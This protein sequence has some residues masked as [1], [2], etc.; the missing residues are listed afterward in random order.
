MYGP[1]SE[2]RA[3]ESAS[4]TGKRKGK[5]RDKRPSSLFLVDTHSVAYTYLDLTGS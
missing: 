4:Q 2:C 5:G 3:T 1:Q